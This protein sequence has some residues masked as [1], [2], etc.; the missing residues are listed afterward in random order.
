MSPSTPVS[1]DSA[2]PDS[3]RHILDEDPKRVT[4]A[5]L[6][7]RKAP[8]GIFGP[9]VWKGKDV[10]KVFIES[11][12]DGLKNITVP[13]TNVSVMCSEPAG[14][15]KFRTYAFKLFLFL[16]IAFTFFTL[17]SFVDYLVLTK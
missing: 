10:G 2:H 11:Q 5:F 13:Y 16:L 15:A 1:I 12:I 17:T 14:C 4:H 7:D 8:V 3:T 6:N 9:F